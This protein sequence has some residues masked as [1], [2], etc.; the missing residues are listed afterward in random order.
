[1]Q[2]SWES[3]FFEIV[4]LY[5][6][7]RNPN[8]S[9]FCHLVRVTG[10]DGLCPSFATRT[11]D[12]VRLRRGQVQV[13]PFFYIKNKRTTEVALSLL[14]RVTGLDGLCPSFATRTP[15]YVRLRRRQVQVL[16]I[17]YIK[18]TE[19]RKNRISAIWCG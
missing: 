3:I 16:D 14:V 12:C 7:N 5:T 17:S 2:L 11:P 18:I 6:K 9:D 15:D 10:L 4:L 13:L 1:M 8:K 19:T